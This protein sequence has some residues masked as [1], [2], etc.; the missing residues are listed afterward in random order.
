MGIKVNTL[1]VNLR[2]LNFEMTARDKDGWTR[3]RRV[4][5][6]RSF[7]GLDPNNDLH[8]S[9]ESAP[10]EVGRLS[11]ADQ[12]RFQS[13]CRRLWADVL[14]CSPTARVSAEQA[15]ICL[16]ERFRYGEQPLDNARDVLAALLCTSPDDAH[17]VFMDFSRFMAQFGPE[18]TVMLKAAALLACSN[19]TGRW[20]TFERNRARAELP[21]AYFDVHCANCL[22]VCH[23]DGGREKVYQNPFV[24]ADKEP[25]LV[26]EEGHAYRDWDDWFD[27]HP[28]RQQLSF[29]RDKLP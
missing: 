4:G 25:Y 23:G 12:N 2:D 20:L 11:E 19:D 5:F 18:K 26:D 22:T 8:A 1:N 17:L 16:A 9:P 21:L 10:F 29:G 3:W 24:E 15:L 6:T 14:Q 27:E 13:E 28:V 7:N